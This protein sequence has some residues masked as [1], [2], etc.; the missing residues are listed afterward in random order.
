MARTKNSHLTRIPSESCHSEPFRSE[1]TVSR[2]G[3]FSPGEDKNAF[4]MYSPHSLSF[5]G[6]MQSPFV[7]T[8]ARHM[9]L[10]LLYVL[11]HA[12]GDKLYPPSSVAV[13]VV[14]LLLTPPR[15]P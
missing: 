10:Y 6:A 3:K 11:P 15:F 2:M 4:G 5:A 13:L 9:R 1:N 14:V 12:T 8:A 7:F